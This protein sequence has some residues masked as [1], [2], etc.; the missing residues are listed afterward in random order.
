[1]GKKEEWIKEEYQDLIKD[2][3]IVHIKETHLLK[4]N[5]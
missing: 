3:P 2:I 1:M 4:R 5:G